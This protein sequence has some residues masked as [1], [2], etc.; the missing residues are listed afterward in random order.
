MSI[1]SK[2]YGQ[3]KQALPEKVLQFG[4]GVL[5]RGL[6]DYFIDKANKQGLFGGSV[7]V[8]KS[9]PGTADDFTRQDNRY[10]TIVKGVRNGQL[11]TEQ[12]VNDC[13]SRVVSANDNWSEIVELSA[14]P[15]IGILISNTTEIGLQYVAESI[16]QSPPVSFPAKLTAFLYQRYQ[17]LGNRSPKTVVIP[18]ELIPDNGLRLKELIFRM[19]QHNQLESSFSEWLA[20]YVTVCSSLVDRIVT[21]ASKDV[22]EAL[23]YEDKLAVQTEPY[24]LWAI[25]G[26]ANV[27][28]LLSF[29]AADTGVVIADSIEYYRERK[30]RLLNGTHTISVCLAYLKGFDTVYEM[31]Q[32]AEMGDF[33]RRVMFD[34][35]V[36]SI[37]VGQPEDL[38]I[39]AEEVIDR[40]RN[41]NIVHQLI[42]ITLQA[43]SKMQMRNVPTLFRY[44]E[45]FGNLPPLMIKGFAAYLLF[46]RPVRKDENRFYG[47]RNGLSYPI[48]DEHAA[49]LYEC[50]Q[51]GHDFSSVANQVCRNTELWGADLAL[52]PGF[53]ETVTRH[54]TELAAASVS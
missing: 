16:F 6:S 41:P 22:S 10:T 7:V 4:T 25:E 11:V 29:A 17:K 30:L 48:Q 31:M 15:Q 13:I 42:N 24:R 28:K 44:Y 14:N 46:N 33:V 36:P 47:S 3:P 45:K 50:W 52:L 23:P 37:A 51:H 18:T 35:I 9:T 38:R 26:S 34:E 21:N 1:L 20:D 49:Y 5:L 27:R 40:F 39:F 54:M 8:V 43:T 32:D 53:T 19:V 12:F 2:D